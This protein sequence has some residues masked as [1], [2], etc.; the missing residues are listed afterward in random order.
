[1]FYQNLSECS[2]FI[3]DTHVQITYTYKWSKVKD[4]IGML[5]VNIIRR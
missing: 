3:C 1:M 4:S 2:L 5:G